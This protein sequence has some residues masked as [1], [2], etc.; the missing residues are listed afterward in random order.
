MTTTTETKP[1]SYAAAEARRV[2]VESL[3]DNPEMI[4]IGE[5]VTLAT[6]AGG[7]YVPYT[8]IETR[9]GG[10]ELVIQRDKTIQL[11][12][13]APYADNGEKEYVPNPDGKIETVTKRN[14]GSYI[15]KGAAKEWYSTRYYVG[16]RR[17]WT[18]Y[19]Q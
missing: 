6:S 2:R 13:G 3:R 18:D 12:K 16:Y 7:L 10:R 19:S 5:G 9:R 11:T 4:E 14:D 8:V 15:V 1:D 17:E